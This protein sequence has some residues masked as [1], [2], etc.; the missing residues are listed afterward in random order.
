MSIVS[1]ALTAYN[2]FIVKDPDRFHSV[3]FE[4][5]SECNRSCPYCPVSKNRRDVYE[6]NPYPI[7]D[8]LARGRFIGAVAWGFFNEPLLHAD[9]LE[10]YLDY[11]S[12]KLPWCRQQIF[13]NGD[14]LTVPV[15]IRLLKRASVVIS[16]HKQPPYNGNLLQHPLMFHHPNDLWYT[17]CH[18]VPKKLQKRITVSLPLL[19]GLTSRGGLVASSTQKMTSCNP[20]AAI[21]TADGYL[22]L[23]CNDYNYVKEPALEVSKIGIFRAWYNSWARRHDVKRWVNLPVPCRS[24]TKNEIQMLPFAEY[25][26]RGEAEWKRRHG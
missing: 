11:V 4:I 16:A 13:T 26:K 18:K 8:E 22:A 9:K 20:T 15:L 23:C 5:S 21:V 2:R 19:G 14:L 6:L 17:I 1:A 7:I 10:A 12:G 3:N 24:C 25:V